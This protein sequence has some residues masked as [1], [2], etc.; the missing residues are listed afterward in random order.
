MLARVAREVVV[1]QQHGEDLAQEGRRPLVVAVAA[2]LRPFPLRDAARPRRDRGLGLVVRV[3][4]RRRG[5][6]ARGPELRGEEAVQEPAQ[7]VDAELAADRRVLG[8]V[9]LSDGAGPRLRRPVRVRDELV[10]TWAGKER[11]NVAST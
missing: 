8:A 6:R 3:V 1:A 5:H 2:G 10:A 4:E 9:D 11:F 7:H